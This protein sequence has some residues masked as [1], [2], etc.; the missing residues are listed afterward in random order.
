MALWLELRD[1]AVSGEVSAVLATYSNQSF[2]DVLRSSVDLGLSSIMPMTIPSQPIQCVVL[3]GVEVLE[4]RDLVVAGKCSAPLSAWIGPAVCPFRYVA[5][6]HICYHFVWGLQDLVVFGDVS[7]PLASCPNQSFQS[8]PQLCRLG[9]VQKHAHGNSIGAN[10]V[11]CHPGFGSVPQ[12]CRLGLVQ[13][14][15]RDNCISTVS[16]PL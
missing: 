4:L 7:A 9:L 15:S 14:Y 10:T 8:V 5:G 13:Q 2:Q 3:Q 1:L 12:L 11:Y 16:R 6:S